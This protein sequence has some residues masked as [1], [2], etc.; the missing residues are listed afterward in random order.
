MQHEAHV[1]LG[2]LTLFGGYETGYRSHYDPQL[3]LVG[4]ATQEYSSH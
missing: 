3:S 4:H 2:P 1:S